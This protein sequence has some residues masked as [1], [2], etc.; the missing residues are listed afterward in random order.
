MPVQGTWANART[1][2]AAA[3]TAL[4]GTA[5]KKPAI[6]DRASAAIAV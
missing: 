6:D 2:I 1:V 5:K 4:I 3:P